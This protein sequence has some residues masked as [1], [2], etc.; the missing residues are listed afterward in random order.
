MEIIYKSKKLENAFMK[1]KQGVQEWG[2]QNAKKLF[3][4]HTQLQAA[5]NLAIFS[6]LP[7][8]GFEQ[9][10][11][12]RKTQFACYGKHP[13]RLIFEAAH[14]PVPRQ[15]DGGVDLVLVTRIRIIEVVDYHGD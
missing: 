12:D 2:D 9:L 3:L 11:G 10:R 1:R 5:D 6:T 4:R 15:S 8:T 7:A 14:D 13:F